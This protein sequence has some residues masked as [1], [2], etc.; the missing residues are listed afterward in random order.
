MKTTNHGLGQD[1]SPLSGR[2]VRGKAWAM[3]TV[4]GAVLSA[5][6][7]LAAPAYAQDDGAEISEIVVTGSR[8][9]SGF[10]TP[11]PVTVTT[12]EQLRQA[13]PRSLAD[14][15]VELPVFATSLGGP[16]SMG[17]AVGQ[18]PGQ[19]LLNLRGLG[20]NRN[21]VL[22]DGRRLVASNTGGS[23]DVNILPQ[24]LVSRVDVVTGGASA[25]YGSDAVTGV[26]NFVLDTNFE[27]MKGEIQGGFSQY[28]DLLSR[29]GS[30]AFGKSFMDGRARVIGSVEYQQEDGIQ[31]NELTGRDWFDYGYGRIPNPVVGATPRFL[32]IPNIRSSVG[33]YGGLITSGPLKGTQFLPGGQTAPFVYGSNLSGAFMTGGDGPRPN[34]ALAPFQ[35]RG[36]GFVHAEYDITDNLQFFVEGQ[37]AGMTSKTGNA[38]SVHLAAGNQYTI[39]QDNAYLPDSVRQQM[40]AQNIA[41]FP[42][43]R[44]DRDFP[45][46]TMLSINQVKRGSIGF[47]GK[48]GGSWIWDT[49]YTYGQTDQKN[50][51]TQITNNRRLYAA[52]DAVRSPVTGQIV[53]RST[54]AGF[55]PGCLPLNLFGEGSPDPAAVAW[56]IGDSLKWLTLKQH[57][58]QV[59]LSGDFGDKLQL[60]A[61]PISM[62]T[63]LEYRKESADQT[64]DPISASVTEFTGVRGFPTSQ[65]NRPG[66]YQFFNPLPLAGEF[67]VKE[68]FVE[69][70]VP[71]LRDLPFAE[72]LD[73]SAA[74]RRADYSNSG[75]VTTWKVGTNYQVVSDVRLRYTRSRDIRGPNILE[76][77]N[78]A[79]QGSSN[80]VFHG[81]TTPYLTISSGNP[82]LAP[83]VADTETYGFVYRPSWLPGLQASVDY[84][85]ISIEGAIG[86]I[87]NLIQRCDQGYAPA[88]AYITITPANTLIVRSQVVNLSLVENK[89]YDFELAYTRPAFGGNLSM[90]LIANH[91]TLDETTPPGGSPTTSLGEPSSPRWRA[92]LQTRFVKDNWSLFVQERY[93]HKALMDVNEVQGVDTNDN[94]IPP[95]LYTTLGATVSFNAMGREQEFFF[96]INNLFNTRPPVSVIN[97]TNYSIPV[98]AAYD[99]VGR[100]FNLGLR[101]K[102]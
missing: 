8:I 22:L 59:N 102:W 57:V 85:H 64:V 84:Y 44:Y 54:L 101:F 50:G 95:I 91:T 65:Q 9:A 78:S 89:G 2:A 7:L 61:G 52:A 74:A 3:A 86:G 32:V 28:A 21:L 94:L 43:G 17:T 36:S 55:D 51:D 100:Y 69:L 25:A 4:S 42:L 14:G 31:A 79:S 63:G 81:V 88:C 15:L 16:R 35:K 49:S 90:R 97:P 77:F 47:K 40:V 99:R 30:L 1:L 87:P 82:D 45:L 93:L 20:A 73:V 18:N 80:T 41:S 96:T 83:E 53:C 10:T 12:A 5:A 92:T 72:S 71:V 66:G 23:V 38:V 48:L 26:V 39:F 62:A 58:V 33:A 76:L 11:T 34:N 46:R 6:C 75:A 19:Y 27:G 70:G 29:G 98:D 60:G 37:Y 68:A 13:A 67:D 56:V 24:S